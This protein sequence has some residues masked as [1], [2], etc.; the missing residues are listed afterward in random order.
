[1]TYQHISSNISRY[2]GGT[3]DVESLEENL[4]HQLPRNLA[5]I[6]N[7]YDTTNKIFPVLMYGT[8]SNSH[9]IS[10]LDFGDPD[11]KHELPCG[12]VL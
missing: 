7:V 3:F 6:I 12:Y 1:M 8:S 9:H 4:L 11:R 10:E 2:L 5:I